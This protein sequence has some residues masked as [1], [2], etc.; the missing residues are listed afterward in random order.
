MV[1]SNDGWRGSARW[2]HVRLDPTRALSSA[3]A[4][5]ACVCSAAME[6]ASATEAGLWRANR[7]SSMGVSPAPLRQ[8]IQHNIF[9][10][11]G[12]V[13]ASLDHQKVLLCF[14][15][16]STGSKVMVLCTEPAT[17][18]SNRLSSVIVSL[19]LGSR[20]SLVKRCVRRP[21]E[22]TGTVIVVRNFIFV[23]IAK[24]SQSRTLCQGGLENVKRFSGCTVY[25]TTR[26]TTISLCRHSRAFGPY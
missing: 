20:L 10:N 24:S 22:C 13:V 4:T 5:R 3:T 8:M 18:G 9:L 17:T 1:V 14:G 2:G 6:R 12:C 11:N 15:S 16:L 26:I 21:C 7:P 23:G 19:L 25:R